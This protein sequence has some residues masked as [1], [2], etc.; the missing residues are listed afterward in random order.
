MIEK[1]KE[2][3]IYA[4]CDDHFRF[5]PLLRVIESFSHKILI[6]CALELRFPCRQTQISMI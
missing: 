3:H 6:Q 4:L 5:R 1:P 2:T